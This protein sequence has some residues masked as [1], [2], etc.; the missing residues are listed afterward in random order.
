M[1]QVAGCQGCGEEV[2]VEWFDQDAFPAATRIVLRP[3]DSAFFNSDIKAEL[4]RGLTR[5]GVVQRGTS[6]TIP[7][8]HLGG[9]EV[10]FDVV[11]T[12]P[13]NIVLAEGDEVVLDFEEA[14]DVP[15]AA[16]AAPEPLDTGEMV[17]A[18]PQ[19]P[20]SPAGQRLGGAGPRIMPDGTRWNPWKHG[21]WPADQERP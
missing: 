9:F 7:I 12:E 10:S 13:A 6:I 18:A 8:E 11:C 20:E 3:H 17:A 19:E 1:A 2:A 16:A 14:L 4:E 15:P 21:P 5:L